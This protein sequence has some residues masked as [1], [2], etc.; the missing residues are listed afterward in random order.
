MNRRVAQGCIS[1]VFVHSMS[2]STHPIS[3][4]CLEVYASCQCSTS[5]S[6]C[7][8]QRSV[9]HRPAQTMEQMRPASRLLSTWAP[10]IRDRTRLCIARVHH[11]YSI[12]DG[13]QCRR[14]ST[15]SAEQ[16]GCPQAGCDDWVC[17]TSRPPALQCLSVVKRLRRTD[18]VAFLDRP[19]CDT[20]TRST[21]YAFSFFLK[22][23]VLP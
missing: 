11:C 22:T 16:V 4:C 5:P 10:S 21:D 20:T 14:E 3:S 7:L 13:C 18:E 2:P 9:L 19:I 6:C 17:W 23:T 8:D 15:L 12:S 1:L